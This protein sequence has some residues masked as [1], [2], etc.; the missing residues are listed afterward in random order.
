MEDISYILNELGEGDM[1]H[2]RAVSPPI[3]QTSNFAFRDV[4]ALRKALG[5]EYHARV[6]SRGN[7]PTIDILRQKLAALDGAE[8]AL[9]FSSG[10]AAISTA[11]LANVGQGDQIISVSRPYSWTEQLFKTLLPR[12]GITTTFVDGCDVRHFED[13]ICG[14]TKLIYLESPNS[15]SYGLQDLEKVAA[16]AKKKDILTL[17]DNSYCTPFYQQP[18]RMGIDLC[19]QSATKYIGGH[20]DVVAGVLTGSKAMIRK[21]F[22]A[23]FLNLGAN[24]SPMNAWLLLRG[25]RTLPVRMQRVSETAGKLIA[26]LEKHPRVEKVLYPLHPSFAQYELAKKQMKG[27]GGLFTILLKADTASEIEQFCNKLRH[28][29][30]GVSWGGYESLVLPALAGFPAEHFNPQDAFHRMIRLYAGLEEADYLIKDLE[31]ALQ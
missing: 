23:E 26:F 3:V 12:F 16:L 21:I 2:Y 28:F 4:S 19:V 14:H 5:D 25:L 30:L 20:S 9:V 7:N 17:V 29:Q 1:E 22:N 6:Y 10:M 15:F 31:Q 18:Y 27:A 13:A 24:I 11:I 8:D